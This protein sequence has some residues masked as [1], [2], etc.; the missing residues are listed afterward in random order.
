[1]SLPHVPNMKYMHELFLP[2]GLP[3][4]ELVAEVLGPEAKRNIE[5]LNISII[6]PYDG[7]IWSPSSNGKF[8]FSS[9][10]NVIRKRNLSSFLY[11]NIWYKM[12]DCLQK[13]QS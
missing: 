9:A 4:D 5:E 8:T 11:K 10:W 1:M 3:N 2:F 6:N 7:I 12:V 13:S